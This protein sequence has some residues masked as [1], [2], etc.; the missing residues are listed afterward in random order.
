MPGAATAARWLDR[1][2]SPQ[3]SYVVAARPG[4]C[5]DPL[6]HQDRTFSHLKSKVR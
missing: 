5:P 3:H 6:V 2:Q 4:A 1:S